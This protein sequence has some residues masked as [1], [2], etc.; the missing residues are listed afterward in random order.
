[1]N[2]DLETSLTDKYYLQEERYYLVLGT[3][4]HITIIIHGG[5]N[6]VSLLDSI[7]VDLKYSLDVLFSMNYVNLH[8]HEARVNNHSQHRHNI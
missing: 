3:L 7:I 1:M 5:G 6:Q 4:V 8:L 2:L